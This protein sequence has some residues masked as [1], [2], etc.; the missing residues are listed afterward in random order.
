M[1]LND[2]HREQ[3]LGSQRCG[4]ASR[5]ENTVRDNAIGFVLSVL[6]DFDNGDVNDEYHYGKSNYRSVAYTLAGGGP[7]AQLFFV[8]DH[9]GELDHAYI[10]YVES[11]GQQTVRIPDWYAEQLARVL[12]VPGVQL[13]ERGDPS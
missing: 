8:I 9:E 11:S 4:H 6:E 10:D 1:P 3:V 12:Q 5:P 7:G 13:P 2:Y